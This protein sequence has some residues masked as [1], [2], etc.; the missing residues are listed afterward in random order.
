MTSWKCFWFEEKQFDMKFRSFQISIIL[1]QAFS[2]K[3]RHLWS[4]L[5][6]NNSSDID[7]LAMSV[8]LPAR[9]FLEFLKQGS[10]I[11]E[12]TVSG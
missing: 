9:L 7:K 5:R 12:E 1:T 3:A 8:F 6:R 2:F 4:S 10:S 11:N